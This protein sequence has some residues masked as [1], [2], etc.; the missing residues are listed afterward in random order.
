MADDAKKFTDRELCRE[1]IP[2]TLKPKA[3]EKYTYFGGEEMDDK[4]KVL[5]MIKR[6]GKGI[7]REWANDFR[8]NNN[9][10]NGNRKRT[11]NGG[12][13]GDGGGGGGNSDRNR[14]RS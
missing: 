14:S 5:K 8:R 1:I 6:I 11:K 2:A 9:K 13:A 3:A 10:N 4:N 12:R 7:D